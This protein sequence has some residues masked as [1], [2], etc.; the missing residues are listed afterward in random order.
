MSQGFVVAVASGLLGAVLTQCL[1]WIREALISRRSRHYSALRL[2]LM[3]ERYALDCASDIELRTGH[4]AEGDS[5]LPSGMKLPALPDF[6]DDI[7]FRS[8]PASLVEPVFSLGVE[9]RFSENAL[10]YLSE[11]LNGEEL[12]D[13]YLAAVAVRGI[14]AWELGRSIRKHIGLSNAVL[15]LGDWNFIE[16]MKQYVPA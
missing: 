2:A 7:E 11:R 12:V 4:H 16:V 13:E 3:C 6:P 8:L 15:D 10:S 1:V 9:V 5:I 14:Q